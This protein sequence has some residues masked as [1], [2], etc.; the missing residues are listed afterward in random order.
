MA[1]ADGNIDY[2]RTFTIPQNVID[3][4]GSLHIVVHG[5]ARDG[6]ATGPV[7]GYDPLFQASCQS[8]AA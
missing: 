3:S 7:G 8:R 2:N 1:D 4:M 6:N 5:L